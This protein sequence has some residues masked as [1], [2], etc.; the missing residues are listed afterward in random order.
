M[1]S[2]TFNPKKAFL[3]TKTIF[4][5]IISGS[6]LYLGVVYLIVT[7]KFFF[8]INLQDPLFIALFILSLSTIPA[9]FFFSGK[10][11]NTIEPGDTIGKKYAIY[12]KSLIIRLA[13]CE[14]VALFAMV[15]LYITHNSFS[16]IFFLFAI[17]VMIRFYP[18]PEKIGRELNLSQTEIN[19]F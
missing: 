2:D 6:L 3:A 9:G 14:G 19:L 13:S 7:E 1:N 5:A 11:L 16:M 10:I 18:T 12:Q 4:F 8:E 15:C 17:V